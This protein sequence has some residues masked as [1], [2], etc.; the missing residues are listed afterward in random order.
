LQSHAKV[1]IVDNASNTPL[2]KLS[3]EVEVVRIKTRMSVG[4]ARNFGLALVRTPLVLFLDADDILLPEAL[5]WLVSALGDDPR[6]VAAVGK[7]L[8]WNAVSGKRKVSSS[9]LPL[10]YKLS[11]TRR[12]FALLTLRHDVYPLVGCAVI[13]TNAVR[14]AGGFGDAS[15]AEDWMLRSALAFRGR[16]L[17]IQEAVVQVRVREGTLWQRAHSRTELQAMC[18]AFRTSRLADSRLPLYARALMPVIAFAHNR[19]AK[20]RTDKGD[21]RPSD[22]GLL[23]L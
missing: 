21:F 3:D 22:H 13:R 14:D 18:K 8:L 2:P 23:S 17:L 11:R 5:T 19:D 6:V 7:H 12:L 9:P 16:I 4:A 20:K 1:L 10:V 15:L